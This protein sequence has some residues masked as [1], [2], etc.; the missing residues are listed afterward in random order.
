MGNETNAFVME[1]NK[2]LVFLIALTLHYVFLGRKI[3]FR[4][5]LI[6]RFFRDFL[7]GD[8]VECGVSQGYQQKIREFLN[9]DV[10][11]GDGFPRFGFVF[12]LTC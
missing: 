9:A 2:F 6:G 7:F 4:D 3:Q 5:E 1:R 12:F 8:L 10:L 11:R